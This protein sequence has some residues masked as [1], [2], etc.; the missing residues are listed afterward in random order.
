MY[1]VKC[2]VKLA[3][4]ETRCP[5]CGT[6]PLAPDIQRT[7]A[8]PLYPKGILPD[9]PARS[10]AGNAVVLVLFLLPLVISLLV[11]IQ[12]SGGITWWGYVAGA[13]VLG[14]IVL[15]LPLWFKK[16]SPIVFLP[17]SFAALALYLLYI[18][19]AT[20][21]GWYLSFA[22]PLVAVAG[23]IVC[24][25]TTL[26]LCVRRGVLFILG[27]TAIALG[28][29]TLLLE[30]LMVASFDY[31]FIGWS[32]YPLSVFFMLGG[33]LLFLAINSTARATMERKLF[34]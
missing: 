26:L 27:G 6:D 19:L 20:G 15:A 8:P 18:A 16:P 25:A 28:G 14:Y 29:Y 4:T 9:I 30:L 11:N 7:T 1:C 12:L 2:G 13:T 17:C 34:F 3:E 5:L 10:P 23:G 22:L 24:A 31:T 33:L 21:G 32:F